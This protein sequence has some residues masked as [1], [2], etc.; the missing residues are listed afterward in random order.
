MFKENKIEEL[1][2]AWPFKVDERKYLRE[3]FYSYADTLFKYASLLEENSNVI[4]FGG[5]FSTNILNLFSI[6]IT[7]VDF[8]EKWYNTWKLFF[9]EEDISINYFEN[10]DSLNEWFNKKFSINFF[11]LVFIDS[12][13]P[14][15][16]RYSIRDKISEMIFPYIKP[17]GYLIFHDTER[18]PKLEKM[19][20]NT[21]FKLLEHIIPNITGKKTQTKV[22]QRKI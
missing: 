3:G 17:G 20:I 10:F 2:N 9:K 7:S 18:H 13:A 14:R 1:Y 4:E 6:N 16:I 19:F 15:P 5:G 22:W 8:Q 12:D 11:S 21:D